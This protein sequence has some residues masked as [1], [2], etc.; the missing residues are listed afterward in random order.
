MIKGALIEAVQFEINK[1]GQTQDSLKQ[2]HPKDIEYQISLAYSSMLKQ[3]F[4]DPRNLMTTDFD[5]Y[6]KKYTLPVAQD[7]A[8]PALRHV[9][10]TALPFELPDGM[11]VR[12]VRPLGGYISLDRTTEDAMDT[13]RLLE[14][15]RT[16]DG[17][18]Y[19]SGPMIFLVYTSA[20]MKLISSVVV[21]MIPH[22]EDLAM[23]DNIEFPMGEAEAIKTVLQLVGIRPTDSVNDDVK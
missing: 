16:G 18:Y 1:Q 22:F 13:Y 17:M 10:L 5:F 21:K 8:I 6:S 7:S 23:T 14:V 2:S 15:F 4:T 3:Y 11:G 12:S 19:L 9:T 20:K